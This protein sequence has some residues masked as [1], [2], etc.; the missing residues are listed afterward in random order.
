MAFVF[1]VCSEFVQKRGRAAAAGGVRQMRVPCRSGGDCA[2]FFLPCLSQE[3]SHGLPHLEVTRVSEKANNRS[4]DLRNGAG[5]RRRDYEPISRV[6]AQSGRRNGQQHRR[7][8]R[9]MPE[10]R[11]ASCM[12]C[13]CFM[14]V[15][16]LLRNLSTANI[17]V[18]RLQGNCSVHHVRC[19]HKKGRS[20]RKC[21]PARRPW[22]LP[23]DRGRHIS[24]V[25][26]TNYEHMKATLKVAFMAT[27]TSV[28]L[29]LLSYLERWMPLVKRMVW[30]GW[31]RR[32]RRKGWEAFLY[33]YALSERSLDFCSPDPAPHWTRKPSRLPPRSSSF[34]SPRIL[35][36]AQGIINGC[37]KT[38]LLRCET[39][40]KVPAHGTNIELAASPHHLAPQ[41]HGR[42]RHPPKK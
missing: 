18:R 11:K 3:A 17:V 30:C 26:K 33:A 40:G 34:L 9:L 13:P 2:A 42:H 7:R 19:S 5:I 4:A 25:M 36:P 32:L 15:T 10:F 20:D 6:M 8:L 22:S 14:P 23:G 39:H 28:V 24:F 12:C 35:S 21:V 27:N 37:L 38:Q 29:P 41:R 16:L 31:R 1:W